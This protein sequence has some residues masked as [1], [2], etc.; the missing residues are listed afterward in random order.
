M[1]FKAKTDAFTWLICAFV[2]I[3]YAGVG[4]LIYFSEGSTEAFIGLGLVWVFLCLFISWILPK[5]TRYTFLEEDLLCQ[6][7]FFKKRIPYSTF[8]KIEPANGLY[9]GWKMSTAWKCLL[10]CYNKYDELLISPA[11]EREFIEMFY[12]KKAQ[13]AEAN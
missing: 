9:A 12:Q 8:R 2:F 7:L 3:V 4:M 13:F 11:N 6:T 10:V 1:V 5:S